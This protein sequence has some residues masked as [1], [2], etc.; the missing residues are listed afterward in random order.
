MGTNY[1]FVKGD[2]YPEIEYGHPFVGLLRGDTG[3]PPMIH[4]G[5]SSGGWCFALHVMPEQNI[6]NLA[7]WKALA[8]R[9]IAEGWHIEDEYREH[10][11]LD[12]LWEVVERVGWVRQDGRPLIRRSTYEG[13][14][15][16]NGEGFY[17]YIRGEFS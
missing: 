14:C 9:L 7:D 8:D 15:L 16:G 1:Y 12:E 5:K 17:D 4:V 11:T 2:H 13:N 10:H 6:C 3:R